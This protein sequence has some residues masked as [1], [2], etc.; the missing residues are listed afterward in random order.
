VITRLTVAGLT[1]RMITRLTIA[2]LIARTIT[3][4]LVVNLTNGHRC[5]PSYYN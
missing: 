4:L 3:M 5:T 1:A 2:T